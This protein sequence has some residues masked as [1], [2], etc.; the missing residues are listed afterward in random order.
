MEFEF[1]QRKSE[2]NENKHGINFI[3]AQD[4]WLD[5]YRMTVELKHKG[6]QRHLLIAHYGGGLWSAVFTLRNEV[7]RIISVRR[8]TKGE[9]SFYDKCKNSYR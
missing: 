4:L 3:E 2:I 9:V 6:E 7:V 5:E 8:S 1:D